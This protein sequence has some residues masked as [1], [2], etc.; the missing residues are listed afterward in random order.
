MGRKGED[1]AER[2]DVR[3]LSWEAGKEYLSILIYRKNRG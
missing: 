2:N 1:W 3:L